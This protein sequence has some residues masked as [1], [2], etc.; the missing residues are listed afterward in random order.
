MYFVTV[1]V[2]VKQKKTKKRIITACLTNSVEWVPIWFINT[3]FE[4]QKYS[5]IRCCLISLT[6]LYLHTT[7]WSL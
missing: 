1:C 5:K 3:K 4:V 2:V 7:H 6:S